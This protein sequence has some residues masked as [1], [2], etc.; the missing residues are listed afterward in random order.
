MTPRGNPSKPGSGVFLPLT[1]GVGRLCAS[2]DVRC[3]S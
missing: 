3:L 2:E 1:L